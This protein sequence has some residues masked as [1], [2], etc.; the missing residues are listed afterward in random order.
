MFTLFIIHSSTILI[1]SECM[2]HSYYGRIYSLQKPLELQDTNLS[3]NSLSGQIS[4]LENHKSIDIYTFPRNVQNAICAGGFETQNSAFFNFTVT[5]ISTFRHFCD[6][7]FFD[8][9]SPSATPRPKMDIYL[10]IYTFGDIYTFFGDDTIN[11]T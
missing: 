10:D 3:F 6:C 4:R 1:G 11:H 8:R 2:V 9:P 7:N 5:N